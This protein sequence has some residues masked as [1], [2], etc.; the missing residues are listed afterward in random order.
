MIDT[1][2]DVTVDDGI[3]F[4]IGDFNNLSVI[5]SVNDYGSIV[6]DIGSPPDPYYFGSYSWGRIIAKDRKLRNYSFGLP[7]NSGN[8]DDFPNVR[9]KS[10]LNFKL[11]NP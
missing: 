1:S 4:T 8:M 5:V 9:R 11:Y 7:I 10:F 2:G 3:E 6:D